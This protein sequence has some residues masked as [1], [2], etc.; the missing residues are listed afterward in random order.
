[1]TLEYRPRATADVSV[2]YICLICSWMKEFM[3]AKIAICYVILMLLCKNN[4]IKK[5][6]HTVPK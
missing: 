4:N 5:V 1:M 2:S 6:K 3:A